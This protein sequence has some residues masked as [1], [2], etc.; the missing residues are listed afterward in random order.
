MC[1]CLKLA[2]YVKPGEIPQTM[3]SPNVS[4][5]VPVRNEE[6]YIASCLRSLLSQTYPAELYEVLVVDG[7]SS[8]RSVNIVE[9]I[10]RNHPNVRW[11]DNPAAIAPAAMNLGIQNAKGNIII[12]ADGHNFYPHNYIEN[13]VSYLTKTGADNVGGPLVTVPA[14][15]SL[16]ARLVAAVLTNPFGVGD[17][18]FRI[19]SKEGFVETVPFGAFRRDVFDRVGMYNE[20]LVRNQ[21]N[22]LNARIR[23][24]GGKI[25][26]TPELTTEYRPVAG[27]GELL[28]QTFKQSQW[29]IFSVREN[30]CSM[31][32]RHFAP[33]LLLIAVVILTILS[34]LNRMAF[35][36]LISLAV[37]YFFIGFFFA[38]RKLRTQRASTVCMLPIACACFHFAYGLGTLAG[39]KYLFKAPSRNPI[40]AGQ[41]IR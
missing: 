16:G 38:A 22:E 20:K 2:P 8:D 37:L 29:H 3:Q 1:V 32:A 5:V 11:F 6:R 25:Y 28:R 41:P 10:G 23:R 39:L 19:G 21:D 31:S 36:A 15:E 27:F 33:A 9:K 13:C 7:R 35:P 17:S 34:F 18:R 12:R 14:N 4:V 26:Q 24:N 30:V 40:R